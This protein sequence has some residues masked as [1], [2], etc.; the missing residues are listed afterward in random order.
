[1]P[2]Y[3]QISLC[4]EPKWQSTLSSCSR[5]VIITNV[6]D[7]FFIFMLYKNLLGQDQRTRTCFLSSLRPFC[8]SL[9]SESLA[10]LGHRNLSLLSSLSPWTISPLLA[11]RRFRRSLPSETLATLGH[12][13]LSLLSAL[14]PRT[15]SPLLA[16]KL[17]R[18]SRPSEPLAALVRQIL[19][20]LSALLPRN[21]SPHSALRLSRRPYKNLAD[22]HE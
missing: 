2:R 14:S 13:N 18:R 7:N 9:P 19:S 11:L 1:M 3:I 21:L 15:I 10:T 12:R 6:L 5:Q 22:D 4:S 16:L 17:S 20:L 8:R